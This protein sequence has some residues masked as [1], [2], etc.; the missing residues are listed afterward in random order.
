[1]GLW[2]ISSILVAASAAYLAVVAASSSYL[3]WC[4]YACQAALPAS[5]DSF[6]S[7]S[8]M[9]RRSATM[10]FFTRILLGELHQDLET[11]SAMA[12]L[13]SLRMMRT[14]MLF[15]YLNVVSK[16]PIREAFSG[17]VG[18][19]TK[20]SFLLLS[21]VSSSISSYSPLS[22]VGGNGSDGGGGRGTPWWS[23]E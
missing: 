8:L 14:T 11:W 22:E 19:G 13:V 16:E 9:A 10:I 20:S 17:P 18:G 23:M 5:A 12:A 6:S 1:L 3:L 2:F 4:Q 15:C 7:S 21:S